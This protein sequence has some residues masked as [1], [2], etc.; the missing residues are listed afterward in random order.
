MKIYFYNSKTG[1]FQGE[2]F[3]NADDIRG[4][5]GV[6][7]V[8]PPPYDKGMIP[9]FNTLSKSWTVIAIGEAKKRVAGRG[10]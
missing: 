6:T 10:Q 4:K 5:D 9:V 2:S 8:P 3:G 7:D 1:V